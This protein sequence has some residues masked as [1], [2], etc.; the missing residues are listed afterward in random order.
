M[1]SHWKV[2]ATEDLCQ[3]QSTISTQSRDLVNVAQLKAFI[4]SVKRNVSFYKARVEY[5]KDELAGVK[6]K[7]TRTRA[8]FDGVRAQAVE[9]PENLAAKSCRD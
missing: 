9:L 2:R 5:L 7:R 4:R 6:A 1:A 8:L 3:A